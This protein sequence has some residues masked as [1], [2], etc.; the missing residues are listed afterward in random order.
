MARSTTRRPPAGGRPDLRHPPGVTQ[1]SP[2]RVWWWRPAQL[3]VAEVGLL[4]PEPAVGVDGGPGPSG[5]VVADELQR[6]L[7]ARVVGTVAAPRVALAPDRR[8]PARAAV[9]VTGGRTRSAIFN[10]SHDARAGHRRRPAAVGPGGARRPRRCR[11]TPPGSLSTQPAPRPGS[12]PTSDFATTVTAVGGPGV[13]VDRVGRPPW[14]RR[15]RRPSGERCAVPGDGHH[16]RARPV[17]PAQPRPWRPSPP[18]PGPPRS[19]WPCST[20]GPRAVTVSTRCWAAT[21][22]RRLG[23]VPARRSPAGRFTWSRRRRWPH[24][25]A[26]P[27]ARSR[28]PAPVAVDVRRRRRPACPGVVAMPAVPPG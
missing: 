6:A 12:P 27:P 9:D 22:R 28:R 14:R 1:P 4:R 7:G 11:P 3:V 8:G 25:P 5:Q 18:V 23:A 16:G 26:W 20:P 15:P 19:P 21:G 24:R 13:V 17:A 10:P 2:S